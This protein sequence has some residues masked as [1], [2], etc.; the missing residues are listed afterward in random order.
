MTPDSA[1]ARA[2]ESTW[3]PAETAEAGGLSVGRG[4][5]GGGRVSSAHATG[6]GWSAEDL[7]NAEA[8]QQDWGQEP[9]FRVAANDTAL[10]QALTQRGYE[11]F[12]PTAIMEVDCTALTVEAIPRLTAFTVWQP[13][14]IQRD[15]WA[16]GNIGEARQ[17]VM[18]RVTLPRSSVLGRLTDRA[19]GAA[20]V[21]A[22][23]PVAMI[24]AIEVLPQFRRMGLAGWMI[25]AAAEWAQAQGASR[26]ALA[27]SR[28]NTGAI[29]LYE[30]MGFQPSGDYAY[31]QKR[32]G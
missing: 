3:P 7:A 1:L 29:A 19:A 26:L 17:A 10:Q 6:T 30:R 4:M 14:A 32:R 5:G 25:R 13:L 28:P 8:I 31:W 2:F 23:G 24:H 21:A 27:V 20:F 16:A 22:D 15:I 11:T 18:D 12:N 9:L